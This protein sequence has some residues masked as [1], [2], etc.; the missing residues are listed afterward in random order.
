MCRSL[1]VAVSCLLL[2][3][4]ACGAEP[5]P[6][7]LQVVDARPDDVMNAKFSSNDGWIGG[8]GINSV[9]LPDD[10][11][12]WIFGDTLVGRI[13]DG[14][15]DDVGM[16]NSSFARQR[17][18]G[19]DAQIELL[20][21]R[22]ADGT[23]TSYIVPEKKPGYYWLWDGIVL[24]GK[25]YVF[26]T[27]LTSPGTITAF[28]W[29]LMDQ[30]LLVVDN[31]LDDPAHWSVQQLDMPFGV[32]ADDYEALWGFEVI[33]VDEHV[34]IYGSTRQ[35]N[36]DPRSLIVARVPPREL[37][38]L[39]RWRFRGASEWIPDPRQA[40]ALTTDVGTEGSVTWL[41]DRQRFVYVYSPPLDP[42]IRMRTAQTPIGPWSEAVTIYTCPE[43]DWDPRI[44]CYAGKA[45]LVPGTTDEL[46][47]TYATNSFD[48][49]PHVTADARVYQPRFVRA[50]VTE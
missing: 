26:T 46:L 38:D 16:V 18:W 4:F 12:L 27:R 22:E 3:R 50:R 39:A 5:I 25:L 21:N 30:S 23:P 34:Y 19:A 24:D 29:K 33:L 40:A 47:I 28:D 42:N 48:M 9:P 14:K 15:R 7:P 35:K 11:V 31:P 45:R 43:V 20:L 41:P 17:G 44:F 8:D 36:G 13:R 49:L 2:V 1:I 37:T 6:A 32:F 10:S